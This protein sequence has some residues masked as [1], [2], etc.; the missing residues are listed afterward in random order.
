MDSKV[1]IGSSSESL[2]FAEYIQ[3][4][5][6]DVSIAQIWNQDVFRPGDYTLERL[7]KIVREY[8]FSVFLIMPDDIAKIRGAHVLIARDNVLFEAGLFFSQL[9]RARTLL[10]VPATSNKKSLDFHL[11]SDLDGITLIKYY[12]PSD[13]KFLASKLGAAC[14]TIKKV[15]RSEGPLSNIQVEEV[16]SSLS[17]GPI[18]LLRH[19]RTRS[20]N[21]PDLTKVLIHFNSV[22]PRRDPVGWD[23]AAKY[24]V[25]TL[26]ALRLVE[27]LGG[28]EY[29][30]TPFGEWLLEDEKVKKLFG[31]EMKKPL[32]RNL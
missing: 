11:P 7:L 21:L 10:V 16:I 12:P 28:D 24:A 5:L 25:Q 8:D 26:F 17:G 30:A 32:L 23:K 15:I 31:R 1:F 9:G 3:R 14:N 27:R 22:R 18:Y 19:I 20:Y 4:Q 6:D 2:E 29:S 13:P